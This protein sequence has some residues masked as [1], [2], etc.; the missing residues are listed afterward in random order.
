VVLRN[1]PPLGQV[2][3]HKLGE[4]V[5]TRS[6]PKSM[7]SVLHHLFYSLRNGPSRAY[8]AWECSQW[9]VTAS[10]HS[11]RWWGILRGHSFC[12]SP[13]RTSHLKCVL[14]C[15]V[16]IIFLAFWVC[17]LYF[18]HLGCIFIFLAIGLYF[19]FLA[20]GLYFIYI[21]GN[22]VV[23]YIFW[24]SGCISY[25]WQLGCILYIFGNWV[26]FYIFVEPGRPLLS[27]S[28]GE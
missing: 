17:I 11:I 16:I 21:F 6:S 23:F 9:G 20:I 4:G 18:W 25:F 19:I 12:I 3:S 8:S 13:E 22:W 27:H 7:P 24:H 14:E 26:V 5:F 28:G 10:R 2:V 15:W 1:S